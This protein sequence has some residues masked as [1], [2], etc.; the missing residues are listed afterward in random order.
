MMNP[1]ISDFGIAK[2]IDIN[3]HQGNTE[4]IVGTYGYMSLEYVMH[5]HYSEKSDVFSFGVI[6][7]EIISS[8]R[9]ARSLGSLDF[10]DLLSYAWKNWRD[11][12]ELQVLD[13]NIVEKSFCYSEVIK[14]IQIGLLCVQQNPDDRL[15]IERVVSYLSSASV[16]LPLPQEPARFMANGTDPSM[17]PRVNSSVDDM[18]MSLTFPR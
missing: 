12:K 13:S 7:L 9:N 15:T 3:Q 1:K 17:I 6:I 16:E 10:N 18:T 14:C 5:G 2:M 4:R 11:K 8:K